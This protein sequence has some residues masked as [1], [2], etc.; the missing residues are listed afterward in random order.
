MP[1]GVVLR[2]RVTLLAALMGLSG[3][4]GFQEHGLK[5]VE[6]ATCV[7]E[8][9]KLSVAFTDPAKAR[10]YLEGL[11]GRIKAREPEA[12]EEAAE[13]VAALAACVPEAS[14]P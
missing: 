13:L 3:C 5:A 4:A 8:D 7:I 12:F 11:K 14:N 1:S 2:L 9:E 10:A 6:A